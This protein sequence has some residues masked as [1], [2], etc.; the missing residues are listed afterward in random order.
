M[1]RCPHTIM[2]SDRSLYFSF[3]TSSVHPIPASLPTFNKPIG[4]T[5]T[6]LQ[7]S[8]DYA[9]S[10]PFNHKRAILS[11]PILGKIISKQVS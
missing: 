5:K 7:S 10:A 9:H 3:S 11:Y 6:W 8:K 2:L 4:H 1:L